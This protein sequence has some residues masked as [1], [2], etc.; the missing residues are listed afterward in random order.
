MI[1]CIP[2]RAE[3]RTGTGTRVFAR[4]VDRHSSTTGVLQDLGE[5]ALTPINLVSLLPQ[6]ISF[7]LL[8][9][10]LDPFSRRRVFR[11]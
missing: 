11:N 9:C 6:S 4:V 3:T 8:E 5:H 1:K 2:A 10:L 7:E